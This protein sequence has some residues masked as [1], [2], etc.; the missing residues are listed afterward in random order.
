VR[1]C[2]IIEVKEVVL[3][4]AS[5]GQVIRELRKDRGWSRAGLARKAKLG[6][7][8]ISMIERGMRP[9]PSAETLAKISDALGISA[10]YIL[11]ESGFKT[12]QNPS[13]Q[14]SPREFEL[15][16]TI[17]HIPTG[18]VRMKVLDLITGF[19]TIA[20]DADAARQKGQE[21]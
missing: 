16:E 2:G 20:R 11:I 5:I 6:E 15:V 13:L 21:Q 14:L 7:S 3:M 19:A 8:T 9:N 1:F 4:A 10:D 18:G 17:R 12:R